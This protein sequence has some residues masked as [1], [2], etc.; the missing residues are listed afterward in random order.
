MK[1]IGGNGALPKY[2]ESD[3]IGMTRNWEKK[4]GEGGYG[5]VYK[6]YIRRPP[7]SSDAYASLKEVF[8]GAFDDDGAEKP[9]EDGEQGLIP[10]AVK[11]CKGEIAMEGR[12]QLLTE[13]MV[14]TKVQ[15][16]HVLALYG[17]CIMD[18]AMAMVAEFVPNGDV[19]EMLEKVESGEATFDFATRM[20]IAVGCADALAFVHEK[21]YI[22]RD[23]KAPNVLLGKGL[24]PK[25]ADFGLV[26]L[27]EEHADAVETR[28]AGAR[29]YIDPAYFESGLL[30]KHCD[31]YA[32]GIFAIELFS[33][34]LFHDDGF[35]EA[36]NTVSNEDLEDYS[37]M[38]HTSM[39]GQWAPQQ[40]Q[41]LAA[42]L[43]S[44]LVDD[45]DD[46]A[47]MAQV[48]MGLQKVKDFK[49]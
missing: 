21:N 41:A 27:I 39:A 14:M 49:A 20:R 22:H 18:N 33:G 40:V 10:V 23:F 28:V 2:T 3:L 8:P 4:L 37:A 48:H 11:M 29:G 16:P 35:D 31:T 36:R 47:L 44:C 46:R 12:E 38:M 30:T 43:R 19:S 5:S 1:P 6:G 25:V 15:H 32:F 17:V 34:K 7:Q 26:R 45:W 9:G 24:T 13:I 42:V